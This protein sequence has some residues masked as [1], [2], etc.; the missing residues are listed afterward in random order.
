MRFDGVVPIAAET[1][2]EELANRGITLE[3]INMTGGGDI[4]EAVQAGILHCDAFIVFGSAK[5]G[6]NT[7]NAACTYY[8]S[9]FAQTQKKRIILVRMIPF[10]QLNHLT[11][12]I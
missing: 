5:Y 11:F 9:K 3:V 6:E 2:R 1:L 10:G 12:Q 4:D 8:E 7:G